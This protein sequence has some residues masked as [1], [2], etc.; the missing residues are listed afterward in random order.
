MRMLQKQFPGSTAE[1]SIDHMLKQM[2]G[3]F[4][5]THKV[6]KQRILLFRDETAQQQN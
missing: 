4:E 1:N 6:I 3:C 5:S 2:N